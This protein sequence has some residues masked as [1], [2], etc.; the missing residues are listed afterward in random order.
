MALAEG[1]RRNG[2]TD[3]RRLWEQATPEHRRRLQRTLFPDGVARGVGRWA[4]SDRS[5]Q[6]SRHHTRLSPSV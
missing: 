5:T 3:A 4:P 2:P 6:R 1:V